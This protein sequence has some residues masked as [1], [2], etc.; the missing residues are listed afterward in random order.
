MFSCYPN[1]RQAEHTNDRHAEEHSSKS[2]HIGKKMGYDTSWFRTKKVKDSER[3]I[4][5][6]VGEKF[7][8]ESKQTK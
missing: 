5:R 8:W 6:S 2:H 4:V 3:Q 1:E 7:K